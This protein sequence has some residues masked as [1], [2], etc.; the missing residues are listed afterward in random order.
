[1]L[2]AAGRGV[3][4]L[5]QLPGTFTPTGDTTAQRL[6]HTVTLLTNGKVLVAGGSAILASW[7]VWSSAE[8]YDPLTGNMRRYDSHGNELWTQSSTLR[9][10]S[11]KQPRTVQA[12]TL[13]PPAPPPGPPQGPAPPCVLQ[14]FTAAGDNLVPWH[15]C[16]LTCLAAR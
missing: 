11:S 10:V 8:L 9:V 16:L 4:A 3:I 7:P 5:A 12:S 1:V 13:V 2:G 14:R 6:G 15:T